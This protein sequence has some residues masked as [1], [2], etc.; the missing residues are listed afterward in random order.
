M[1]DS[2][3]LTLLLICLVPTGAPQ[4]F[5][6]IGLSQTSIKLQWDPPAKRHRNGEIVLYE[7]L[8]H[9]RIDSSEDFATNSTG[10][11]AIVDGLEV[12]TDYIFQLRAYTV[13]GSGP[14][15]NKL[16]FR[17]FGHCKDALL[18]VLHAF[19]IRK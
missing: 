5:T 11:M 3:S 14:W 10:T 16:P 13:K 4:N 6:A 9:R 2:C 1:Q 7:I 19:C 8:Y 12:S 15:S 17:T 18:I